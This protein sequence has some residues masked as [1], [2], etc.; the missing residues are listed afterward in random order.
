MLIHEPAKWVARLRATAGRRRSR[1]LFRAELGAG[2]HTGP[3]GRYD[4]LRYEAEILAFIVTAAGTYRVNATFVRR[5][6]LF[7]HAVT[8]TVSRPS[9]GRAVDCDREQSELGV[10]EMRGGDLLVL[11]PWVIFGAGLALVYLRLRRSRTP[12]RRSPGPGRTRRQG[13]EPGAEN[14]QAGWGAP[15]AGGSGRAGTPQSQVLTRWATARCPCRPKGHDMT[16]TDLTAIV[17][18]IVAMISLAVW[19]AMV[20]YADAHPAVREAPAK[21]GPDGRA[22]TG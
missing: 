6:L 19:L 20:F 7:L 3:A 8:T 2:A 21:P 16:G 17:L 22:G 4:Q 10:A 14:V 18:P 9:H 15:A 1:V 12:S 11:A 13:S 5:P